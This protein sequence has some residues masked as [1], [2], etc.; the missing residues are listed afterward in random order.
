MNK[1]NVPIY[2]GEAHF[3]GDASGKHAFLY[4]EGGGMG[5]QQKHDLIK[6][7]LSRPKAPK[8][9]YEISPM[10]S[11]GDKIKHVAWMLDPKNNMEPFNPYQEVANK[12]LGAF[13]PWKGFTGPD[14][15]RKLIQ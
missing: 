1:H 10:T 5:N 2:K 15:F 4:S 9:I 13:S 7:F 6:E 14:D 3:Y 11:G 8:V 12:F